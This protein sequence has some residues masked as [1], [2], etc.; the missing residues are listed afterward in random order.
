[1][2]KNSASQ[3]GFWSPVLAA[4]LGISY[5]QPGKGVEPGKTTYSK[6]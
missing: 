1:M 6:S 3:L 2:K 4:V 5:L